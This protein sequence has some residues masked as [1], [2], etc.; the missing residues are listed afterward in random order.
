M[1]NHF[2]EVMLIWSNL[3]NTLPD[4]GKTKEGIALAKKRHGD[5]QIGYELPEDMEELAKVVNVMDSTIRVSL[6]AIIEDLKKI[7]YLR[8]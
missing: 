2:K 6:D 5:I 8:S 7:G 1:E 3:A 4:V